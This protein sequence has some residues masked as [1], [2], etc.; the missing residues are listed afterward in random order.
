MNENPFTVRKGFK[1]N[2]HGSVILLP[3]IMGG[4]D[5][6]RDIEIFHKEGIYYV[7]KRP[8]HEAW[9][10]TGRRAYTPTRYFLMRIIKEVGMGETILRVKI[11]E[12]QYATED[13]RR[14]RF[15]L[16][17]KAGQYFLGI[18]NGGE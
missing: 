2:E 12:K 6:G 10:G 11:I 18:L 7:G 9:A 17:L 15:E 4:V 16:Q 3:R 13:W 8:G 5:Y 14:Q 1:L